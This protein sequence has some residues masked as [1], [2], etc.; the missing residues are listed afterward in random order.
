VDPALFRER[1][2]PYAMGRGDISDLIERAVQVAVVRRRAAEWRQWTIDLSQ[3]MEEKEK[4]VGPLIKYK[5][6][7]PAPQS[8]ADKAAGKPPQMILEDAKY[9]APVPGMPG[10]DADLSI[11]GRPFFNTAD[12]AA[13]GVAGHQQFMAVVGK[14]PS[15]ADAICRKM[16]ADLDTRR[17]RVP[18][19]T[20]AAVRNAI[21]TVPPYTS[22]V[23][24][25]TTPP[26]MSER[27]KEY[28]VEWTM[29][30]TIWDQRAAKSIDEEALTR[31]ARV[32][33]GLPAEQ[34]TGW[35]D[36]SDPS[37]R[38]PLPS[39]RELMAGLPLRLAGF[40][41]ELEPGWMGGGSAFAS[42]A[43]R[44]IGVDAS[45]IFETP[46][47]VFEEMVKTAPTGP[48]FFKDTIY[49][50]FSLGGYVPPQKV[51]VL[52]ELLEKNRDKLMRAWVTDETNFWQMESGTTDYLKT[53]EPAMYAASKG[54]GYL[55]AAEIYSGSM[56]WTN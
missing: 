21:A 36:V 28:S 48:W 11:W 33:A 55:E 20:S 6:E 22:L 38:P 26:D 34:D 12:G 18:A 37:Q 45:H 54:W 14:P 27:H 29:I 39:G 7:K 56:G 47:S 2:V 41:A 1:L 24:V 31:A 23:K 16:L 3:A 8:A 15:Q 49:D 13:A 35:K 53:L 40:A 43:F 30:R 52:I 46:V 10:F 42:S 17:S 5:A 9:P 4:K 25:D 51:P 32:K 50:N 19:D 44:E